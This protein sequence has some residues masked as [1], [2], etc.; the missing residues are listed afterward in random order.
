MT[1]SG[2][3]Y[4]DDVAEDDADDA[5]LDAV[6]RMLRPIVR[7]LFARGIRYGRV[8]A[9]LRDAF[10]AIAE[11][12]LRRAGQSPTAS[13]LS[14]LS[15]I[16]RKA[17]RRMRTTPAV[18]HRVAS[19]NRTQAASLIGLWLA[20]PRAANR[21]GRARPIPIRAERGPSFEKLARAVTVDV[22]PGSLLKDLERSGAVEVSEDGM[23]SLRVDAYGPS[24]GRPEKLEMLGEDPPELV[25]TMLHNI[26]DE[27]EEK[28]LQRKVFFDNLGSDGLKGARRDMRRV[29]EAF[30]RTAMRRLAKYDRDRNP[31]APGGERRYAGIGVY[32]FEAPFGADAPPDPPKKR[33]GRRAR[34]ESES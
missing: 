29:G 23:V 28:L 2:R 31:S 27:S 11:D 9:R 7:R 32:F 24:V 30:L 15:G 1:R 6:S 3:V 10:L 12:E 16:N 14:L 8:E 13:A 18:A 26:F 33:R 19:P 25:A 4:D 22:A 21:K 20:D 34:K 5:L 17:V